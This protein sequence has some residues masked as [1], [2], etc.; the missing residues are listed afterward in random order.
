[1]EYI[2]I[3]KGGKQKPLFCCVFS[4]LCAFKQIIDNLCLNDIKCEYGANYEVLWYG[5]TKNR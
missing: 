4:P 1:M 2:K 5:E 3:I